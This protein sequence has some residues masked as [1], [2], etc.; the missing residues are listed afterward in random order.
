MQ[1]KPIPPVEMQVASGTQSPTPAPHASVTAH[2]SV[3]AHALPWRVVPI[4]QLQ[5]KLPTVSM[6]V[7][8]PQRPGIAVHSFTFVHVP[9]IAGAV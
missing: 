9:P 5:L 8:R 7:P 1:L 3:P 4:G 2:V 6:H